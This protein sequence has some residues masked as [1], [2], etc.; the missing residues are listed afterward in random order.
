[1]IRALIIDDEPKN[2]RV[3]KNLVEQFCPQVK[4]CGEAENAETAIRLIKEL[5][6]GLVFLDIEMPY[7]NA[8]DMLDKLMPVDFEII[9]IT[10]FDE[11]TLKAFKYSAL[12]Y[13]LK[14]VNIEELKEAVEK[15]EKR[16]QHKDTNQQ[17][18]NLLYN[19]K[20]NNT[21]LQKIA[22]P[23]K[24]SLLF[25]PVNN[26]T[27]CEASS[28]YCNVFTSDGQKFLGTKTIKEY[29]EMLPPDV[30]FRIHNSHLINL[31]YVRKY[32]KGRGGLVEME[33]GVMIEVA[34]RRKEEFLA[35]FGYR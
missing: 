29:E 13:L 21:T 33:D 25:V 1:M 15:A 20:K 19:L 23:F 24:E 32:L 31:T 17:L 14:P 27:R 9:F 10:A 26:I 30:F 5:H 16:I 4:I 12:D 2:I 7:G 22:L 3:L 11:Y 8:F 28:G 18:N 34:S 35:R 6:P